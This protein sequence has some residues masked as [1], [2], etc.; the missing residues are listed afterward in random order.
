MIDAGLDIAIFLPSLEWM[1]LNKHLSIPVKTTISPPFHQA[2]IKTKRPR[3][4][5]HLWAESSVYAEQ[6]SSANEN[7]GRKP[8]RYCRTVTQVYGRRY[9][10]FATASTHTI[11]PLRN[12]IV[13]EPGHLR[14]CMKSDNATNNSLGICSDVPLGDVARYAGSGLGS[15]S[16][17]AF[18]RLVP[19]EFRSFAESPF[20]EN[21]ATLPAK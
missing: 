18:D 8:V 2:S 20:V 21:W 7:Q 9:V 12:W 13:I 15:S 4:Y 16:C 19:G 1:L 5:F 14:V 6:R 17:S 3:E 11:S 10:F